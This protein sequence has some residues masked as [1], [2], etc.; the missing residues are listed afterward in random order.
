L[1][2]EHVFLRC[3]VLVVSLGNFSAHLVFVEHRGVFFG[4]PSNILLARYAPRLGFSHPFTGES[5]A[6]R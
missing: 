5:H 3:R 2:G 4:K 6:G 1:T